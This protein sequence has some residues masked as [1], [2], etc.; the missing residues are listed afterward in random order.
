MDFKKLAVFILVFG[1]LVL[2]YGGIKFVNN[3]PQAVKGGTLFDALSIQTDNLMRIGERENAT[4]I[5]IGGGV[6]LFVGIGIYASAK[7]PN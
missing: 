3:Q 1:T 4:K 2:G 5:M 6:I 7:R